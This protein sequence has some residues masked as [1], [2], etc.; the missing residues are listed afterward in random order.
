MRAG[1]VDQNWPGDYLG[2]RHPPDI[3]ITKSLSLLAPII[4][5]QNQNISNLSHEGI[6]LYMDPACS[7]SRKPSPSY[8]WSAFFDPT[9]SPRLVKRFR[10]IIN[11]AASCHGMKRTVTQISNSE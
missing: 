8:F 5:I 11:L 3:G 9:N 7:S 10:D 1:I 2:V 4:E 6:V